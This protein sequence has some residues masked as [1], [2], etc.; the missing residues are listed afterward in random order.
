MLVDDEG[1]N[2][3]REEIDSLKDTIKH[4]EEKLERLM[5]QMSTIERSQCKSSEHSHP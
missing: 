4:F 1:N 3:T 2:L 5:H